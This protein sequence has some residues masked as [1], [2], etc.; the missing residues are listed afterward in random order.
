[1]ADRL[2]RPSSVEA[3]T[4]IRVKEQNRRN[5]RLEETLQ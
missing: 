2:E 3:D 4:I 1:M 5:I